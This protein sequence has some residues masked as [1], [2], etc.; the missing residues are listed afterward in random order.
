MALQELLAEV[1]ACRIC[2]AQ[3]PLGARPVVQADTGARILI[4]G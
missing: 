2:E 4:V 1:R 3:L